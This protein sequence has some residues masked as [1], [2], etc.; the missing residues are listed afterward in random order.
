MLK[1]LVLNGPNLNMLGIR[2]P[3]LYGTTSLDQINDKL[4]ALAKQNETVLECKQS[5]HEGDL[6]DWLQLAYHQ[7]VDFIIINAGA[8]THT[9]IALRDALS[10]TNIPFIEVHLTNVYNREEFRH[11]SLLSAI[12]TGV[13]VGLG[14]IGY[15]FALMAAI[16]KLNINKPHHKNSKDKK[17]TAKI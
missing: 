11:Q 12:A 7:K 8:L 16:H 9:S 6:I 17:L 2:Q 15:E 4:H 13:I 10:G 14:P 5:N 3:E 1:I